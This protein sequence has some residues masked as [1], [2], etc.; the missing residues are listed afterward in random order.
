MKNFLRIL[1]LEKE[2]R[3]VGGRGKSFFVVLKKEEDNYSRPPAREK[4]KFRLCSKKSMMDF[5]VL[6]NNSQQKFAFLFRRAG[7]S[8]FF[9][10]K[11]KGKIFLSREKNSLFL[12]RGGIGNKNS[13]PKISL[14]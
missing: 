3:W 10:Q 4:S 11:E 2:A 12:P 5:F 14:F 6:E 7:K 9:G 1:F 8:I 13:F